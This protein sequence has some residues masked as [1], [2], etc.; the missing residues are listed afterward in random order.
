MVILIKI[1]SFV[2]NDDLWSIDY[3]DDNGD[4]NNFIILITCPVE[5]ERGVGL[6]TD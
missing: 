6:C 2:Y 3:H 4:D 5:E 1:L